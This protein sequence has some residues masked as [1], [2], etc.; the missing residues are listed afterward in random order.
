MNQG[1]GEVISHAEDY[2]F[3]N[4]TG[5]CYNTIVNNEMK[6]SVLKMV[7]SVKP[8]GQETSCD[9]YLF[10]DLVHPSAAAHK[11]MAEKARILLDAAGVQFTE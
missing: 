1:F 8:T 4:I 5:T 10:F 6:K 11:I 3:T 7:A 2:G 9:G